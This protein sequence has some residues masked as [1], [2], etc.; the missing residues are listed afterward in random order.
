LGDSKRFDRGKSQE[1][2]SGVE[3]VSDK[4]LNKKGVSPDTP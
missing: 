4:F 1:L 3:R 2:T